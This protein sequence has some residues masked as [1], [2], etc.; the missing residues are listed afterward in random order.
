MGLH[1]DFF[2]PT[3][4]L[5]KNVSIICNCFSVRDIIED[6]AEIY[7]IYHKQMKNNPKLSLLLGRIF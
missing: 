4:T 1:V 6:K 2:F 3:F 5:Q 7:T